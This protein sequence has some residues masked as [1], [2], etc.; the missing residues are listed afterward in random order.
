MSGGFVRCWGGNSAGELG[1]GTTNDCLLPVIVEGVSTATALEAGSVN[2]CMLVDNGTVK[3]TGTLYLDADLSLV[4]S[5][6]T[7]YDVF[8]GKIATSVCDGGLHA[9]ALISDGTVQCIGYNYTGQ[10]GSETAVAGKA[11]EVTGITN[12]TAISCGG[13]HTCALL[14]DHTI[15][16]WGDNFSLQLGDANLAYSATPVLVPGITNATAVAAGGGF[17]CAVMSDKTARCWGSD[18][19]GQLGNNSHVNV[20]TPVSVLKSDLSGPLSGITVLATGASHVC[21][22][23]KSNQVYCWGANE[24]GQLGDGSTVEH[25]T[26][27]PVQGL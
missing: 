24:F 11:T 3:C 9:C 8:P 26:P 15:A 10:L 1:D 2:T 27:V 6:T 20:A 12:A 22:I 23:L 4:I 17:T 21:A 25:P 7:P 16:C 13:G 14:T 18:E 5:D 19:A